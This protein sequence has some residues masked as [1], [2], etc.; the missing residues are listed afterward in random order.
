M[1]GGLSPKPYAEAPPTRPRKAAPYLPPMPQASETELDHPLVSLP[2]DLDARERLIWLAHVL[3]PASRPARTADVLAKALPDHGPYDPRDLEALA[4]GFR[5]RGLL[6]EAVVKRGKQAPDPVPVPAVLQ[7]FTQDPA[8]VKA[9]ADAI[10][11]RGAFP[12]PYRPGQPGMRRKWDFAFDYDTF[13]LRT[14]L[15]LL[16]GRTSDFNT[17][18]ADL[19]QHNDWRNPEAKE[20]AMRLATE[21]L[22]S[23]DYDFWRHTPRDL[24]FS[25][26]ARALK[27]KRGATP[28]QAGNFQAFL[29]DPGNAIDEDSPGYAVAEL[30]TLE[31][32]A[33]AAMHLIV[34]DARIAELHPRIGFLQ[35]MTAVGGDDSPV[36]RVDPEAWPARAT[37]L[38]TSVWALR[39]M[40]LDQQGAFRLAPRTAEYAAVEPKLGRATQATALYLIGDG[41]AAETELRGIV[42]D[43]PLRPEAWTALTWAYAWT[44]HKLPG[45]ALDELVAEVEAEGGPLSQRHY[46]RGE[47]VHALAAMYPADARSERWSREADAIAEAYGLRYLLRLVPVPEAWEYALR[48]MTDVAGNVEAAQETAQESR[49]LWIVDPDERE[50][51]V[52]EQKNGKRGWSKGRKLSPRDLFEALGKGRFEP[53]DERV[54]ARAAQPVK[55]KVVV[56]GMNEPEAM[57]FDY[58]YTLHMLEDHPRVVLDDERRIPLEVVRGTPE[59]I[60]DEGEEGIRLSF[61]PPGAQEG[62]HV[63]KE[64]PTRYRVYEVSA[65]Q[66]R[67]SRGVGK[68]TLVPPARR[69]EIDAKLPALRQR[70][71]VSASSDLVT[72]DLPEETG[73]SR[74]CAH[75][76]PYGTAYKLELYARPLPGEDYYARIGQ[77]S[78]RRA[79]IQQAAGDRPARRIVLVRDLLA[80]ERAAEAVIH[81]CPTLERLPHLDYEWTLDDDQAALRV[82]LELRALQREG[83]ISV[84]HPKGERL[85]LIG[86]GTSAGLSLQVN[87]ERDWFA[88]DGKLRTDEGQVLSFAQLLRHARTTG[89]QFVE[90]EEGTFV[91]ITEELKSRLEAIEGLVTVTDGAEAAQLTPLAALAFADLTDEIEDLEVDEAWRENLQRI[92]ETADFDPRVPT[93]FQ[94]E[95]RPYQVDGYKWLRRL[96]EWG[97]GGCLA[98]DMGLGKT[99]QAL[100]LLTSRAAMGPALVIAPA[101]VT[102]NWHAET[103]RFAPTLRPRLLANSFETDILDD[104]QP[105]DLLLVSYGL[106]SFV[107][108]ALLRQD[109]ATVVLDEAQAIKNPATKRAKLVFRLRAQMRLATTGTPIENHLGELWSLFRFINPGLLGSASAFNE[110]FAA[111]IRRDGKSPRA[112]QLRRLVQPFILRRR[113]EAVL[114]ELPPKTEV[115]LTVELSSDERALYEAMRRQAVEEITGAAA[116]AQRMIVLKQ[117]TLLR[118]AACHPRLVR[119]LSQLPSAKLELVGE[120]IRELIDNGH[121]ALVFSQFVKHLKLVEEWVQAAGIRYCYLDGSTPGGKRQQQVD[122]FQRGE[123][124][125]FLISLKAGGTGLNLTAADYVLHLDPW[126]NP[127]VED[128]ASDRAHRIG[129]ERPVTVY[130]FVSAGTIEERI[131]GLHAE[132]RD[133]ADQILAGSELSSKLSVGEV[134]DLLREG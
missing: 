48:I 54:I 77:G 11:R 33:L 99:V 24:R 14:L 125:V 129:Q 75:L 32:M 61:V 86:A 116:P 115:N 120:T 53:V 69:P 92:A 113:K 66:A 18:L 96:A 88:V 47:I 106:L 79:M 56:A 107:E 100:A 23:L 58:G 131:I 35:A 59:L 130:R 8:A 21:P 95:L 85:K 87:K 119:P 37:T 3:D 30:R 89:G 93:S 110:R 90:L 98:D 6:P 62:Y 28:D 43:L 20:R 44:G 111:P 105:G 7:A 65:A 83:R 34:G 36:A 26:F 72:S 127:A 25:V 122:A 41:E 118:Q 9:L 133:L 104:L 40:G 71:R 124:E 49:L 1:T 64:T 2:P 81:D 38:A 94:A 45:A 55:P 78:S 29:L 114:K 60:V 19:R 108:E 134:V 74:P 4:A 68:Q 126:W 10:Y 91:A 57:H 46:L 67:L 82:L 128:Q 15:L 12:P 102:R 70:V 50:I 80:E 16:A 63:E 31:E 97:V 39:E 51:V 123:A 27:A 76:L 22:R 5:D 73:D 132:K 13:P 109:F 17:E 84:E 121:K 101:S 117:L 103:I 112:E 42:K 52:R